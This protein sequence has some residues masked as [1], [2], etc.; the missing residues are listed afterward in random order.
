M[1]WLSP[2]WAPCRSA[3]PVLWQHHR[4]SQGSWLWLLG[5][6]SVPSVIKASRKNDLLLLLPAWLWQNKY[7][8]KL[9]SIITRRLRLL[10]QYSDH[11]FTL[12]CPPVWNSKRFC[13]PQAFLML[14]WAKRKLFLLL[15]WHLEAPPVSPFQKLAF[16]RSTVLLPPLEWKPR[17]YLGLY[18]L[19]TEYCML[20]VSL[21]GN[22]L[23]MQYREDVLQA[24]ETAALFLFFPC[25][26]LRCAVH[27]MKFFKSWLN[28]S[29]RVMFVSSHLGQ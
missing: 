1:R 11:L 17:F 16:A 27:Y 4:D 25:I 14:I 28:M 10:L 8:T 9:R 21:G 7:F 2:Q 23:C 24:S 15:F 29:L 18:F 26:S 19:H 5:Q 6:T 22:P 13:A 12:I 20:Y 3:I